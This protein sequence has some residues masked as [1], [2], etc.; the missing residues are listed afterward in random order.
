MTI[1]STLWQLQVLADNIEEEAA[2]KLMDRFVQWG[3]NF[4]D[5]ADVYG[6]KVSERIL[7]TWLKK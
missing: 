2:H 3:G 6:P 1:F 7:G 4:F 5:S